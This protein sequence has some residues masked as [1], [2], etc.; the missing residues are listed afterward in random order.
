MAKKR[1]QGEG[2]IYKRK[3][4]L[5]VAQIFTQGTKLYKYCKTQH[6]ARDWLQETRSKIQ[7]GLTLATAQITLDQFLRQWLE[8]HKISLRPKTAQQYTQIVNQYLLPSLGQIKLSDLR[9]DQIQVLYNSNLEAGKSKRTVLL[10]HAILNR[11][12]NQALK[13]GLIGRNPAQVANHPKYR[14]SE[15]NT[16]ADNQI[17]ELLG[18]VKGSRY[19]ALYLLAVSTGLREGELLGLRWSDIDWETQR[20]KVQRQIQRVKERGLVFS[21][22]KSQAGNRSVVLGRVVISKLRSHR[23]IQAYE[24][25]FAG[26]RWQ[27]NNLVFP[28]IIGTAWDPRNL[29]KHF[30]SILYQAALPN[31]RFHDLRHTAATLMLGQGI[32]PKVVQERLGH[33]DISLTLNTY[34]HVL[35]DIQEEAAEKFDL[36]LVPSESK[37]DARYPS[38]SQINTPKIEI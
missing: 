4:G 3:D 34:S 20:L 37:I 19:E 36:L 32:H 13:W 2:S 22:P 14:R 7:R 29:Y 16:L 8:S 5:W 6:E 1:G 33:A 35:P 12:L 21:E 17:R 9:P 24:R 38:I 18:I 10:I 30:K 31:I 11:A 26:D 28:S 15:I 27:E 25:L 23:I